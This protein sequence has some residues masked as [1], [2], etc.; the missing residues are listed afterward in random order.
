MEGDR[1]DEDGGRGTYN[2]NNNQKNNKINDQKGRYQKFVKDG[3]SF[4]KQSEKLIK[5]FS[6]RFSV[7]SLQMWPKIVNQV[8]LFSHL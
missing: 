1:I 5:I 6:E 3:K 2:S 4:P 7:S 8:A